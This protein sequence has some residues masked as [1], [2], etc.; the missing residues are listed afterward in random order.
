MRMSASMCLILMEMTGAPNTLPFLMLVIVIAKGVGDR[1][2]TVHP[3]LYTRVC[4]RAESTPISRCPPC[5]RFNYSVFDHQ[6]MLK[7]FPFIGGQ[8]EHV[9]KRAHLEVRGEAAGEA[10]C[11]ARI[12]TG[13]HSHH[14]CLHTSD[15]KTTP[16]PP[17]PQAENVMAKSKVATTF[18]IVEKAINLANAIDQHKTVSAFPV[19]TPS[20]G[21]DDEGALSLR[22]VIMRA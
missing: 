6:I 15:H 1:Y 17:Y 7:G 16:H 19:V 4:I 14:S 13:L 11:H 20:D 8:P 22:A 3:F 18:H 9:V 10:A 5:C 21:P 12:G 2:G